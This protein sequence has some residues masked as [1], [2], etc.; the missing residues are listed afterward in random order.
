MKNFLLLLG[1]L[2]S[3]A[4]LSQ[5]RCR[6]LLVGTIHQFQ[7]TLLHRQNMAAHVNRLSGWQPQQILIEAIPPSDSAGQQ[8]IYKKALRM[9]SR[10]F[11]TPG[12]QSIDSLCRRLSRTT[13]SDEMLRLHLVLGNEYYQCH[14]F[15]N[16]YYHWFI[17]AKGDTATMGMKL[18]LLQ[19]ASARYQRLTEFGNLVFPVAQQISV[20]RL[21]NF[22]ER[23]D[24]AEFQRLGKH[25]VKRLVLNLK[26]FKALKTFRHLQKQ[27]QAA[28]RY[29][30]LL[31]E[32]NSARFQQQL[33]TV[34]DQVD[35]TWVRSRKATRA[36][37]LWLERNRRMAERI[38]KAAQEHPSERLIVFVGAAHL[39]FI[40]R[41]LL[42]DP[43]M[44][45]TLYRDLP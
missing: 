39:E 11:K 4:G 35:E 13:N 16:A 30:K 5:P 6:V 34:I 38:R 19:Q 8:L 22:D 23:S 21:I 18:D 32:I 27:L 43:N 36:R 40:R 10:L 37:L 41:E 24:D 20:C 17:A 44:E 14:D 12:V 15:W 33:V 31:E 3:L 7:D 28:E 26:V 9:A 25:L 29:G 45:I 42:K 2:P 1:L